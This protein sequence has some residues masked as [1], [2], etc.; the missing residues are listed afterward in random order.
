MSMFRYVVKCNRNGQ[1]LYLENDATMALTPT[2]ALAQQFL[3]REAA[4]KCAEALMADKRLN[5]K[6]AHAEKIA[7]G[8]G[9]SYAY[10]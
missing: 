6:K 5:V 8:K 10:N 2:K 9:V 4:I 7:P 1:V 3:L